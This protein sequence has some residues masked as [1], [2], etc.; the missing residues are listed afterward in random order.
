MLGIIY[1]IT[2]DINNKVYVG[3]TKRTLQERWKEHQRCKCSTNELHMLIKRAILKYGIKHFNIKVLEKCSFQDLN[4]REIYYIKFYNAYYEGYNMTKGGISGSKPLKLLNKQQEIVELYND[5]YSLRDIA[6]CYKVDKF[7]I[8]HILEINS[9]SLREA[10]SYKF[11]QRD[12][13]DI[14]VDVKTMSRKDVMS[15]WK[16]PASYLSQ[17]ING[18]RRI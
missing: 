16:I 3:Q 18:Q 14:L 8:K 1:I 13:Q 4:K 2:N 12:R 17:L 15:K 11:S 10:R 7:T 6:K 5:G 9:V